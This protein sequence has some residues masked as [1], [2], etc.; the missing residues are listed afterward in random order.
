MRQAA[1]AGSSSATAT[2]GAAMKE[3]MHRFAEE[4]YSGTWEL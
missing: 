4:T 1:A 2:K 3:W